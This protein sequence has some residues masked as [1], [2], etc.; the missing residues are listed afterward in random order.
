MLT[1]ENQIFR[2]NR[3]IKAIIGNYCFRT[4]LIFPRFTTVKII[5]TKF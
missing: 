4:F 1:C 3:N 2:K 5:T